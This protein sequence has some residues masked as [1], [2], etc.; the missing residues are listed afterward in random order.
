M[1]D[2]SIRDSFNALMDHLTG[3]SFFL[4][5]AVEILERGMIERALKAHSANQSEAARTL[6]IHRNTLQRKMLEYGIDGKR[7]KPVSRISRPA[8]RRAAS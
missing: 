1:K 7:R 3:K 2:D 8:A 4:E 5:E 6:G